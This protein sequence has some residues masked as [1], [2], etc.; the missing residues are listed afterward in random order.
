[1]E[2][3]YLAS[4]LR[5]EYWLRRIFGPDRKEVSERMETDF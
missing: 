3:K 1:M 2:C 5:T 4:T